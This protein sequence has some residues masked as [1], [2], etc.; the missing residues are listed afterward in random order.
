MQK[1]T[2]KNTTPKLTKAD[3]EKG[4]DKALANAL[5]DFRKARKYIQED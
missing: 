2:S 4:E 3:L 1:D 5:S